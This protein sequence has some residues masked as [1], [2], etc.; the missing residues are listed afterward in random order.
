M[1]KYEPSS[2]SPYWGSTT[3]IVIGVAV[4][5]L[6][7]A[8]MVYFRPIIGPLLLSIIMTYLLYPVVENLAR[9]THLS[10]RITVNIVYIVLIIVLLAFFAAAGF[11]L[12]QQ[13][14]SLANV[15]TDFIDNLPNLVSS[16][17]GQ[18]I[19]IGPFRADLTHLNFNSLAK[20]ALA[21]LQP[22]LGQT[23]NLLGTVATGTIGFFGWLA[24][25]V[26]ISYF[27]LSEYRK[28]GQDGTAPYLEFPGYN[29]DF[30]RLSRELNRIWNAFLRGQIF[31]VLIACVVYLIVFSLLGVRFSLVLGI[32]AGMA[33]FVP[34]FGQWTSII[35][36]ALIT[37]FQASNYLGIPAPY[38]TLVVVICS[39]FIDLIMDNLVTPRIIG[40]SLGLHPAV[41]L[42]AA[43]V[44]SQLI[45]FTGLV[46]AAPMVG[47]L[48]LLGR[49]VSRK[50]F[51][52]DPWLEPDVDIP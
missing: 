42:V 47:T 40:Q 24:F 50:L 4:V 3:K 29:Y 41:I 43:L 5:A 23:G 17:P 7:G 37:Y 45:G 51:N 36:T 20:Q 14:Q 21:N 31:V 1:N 33:R 11:A 12:L 34:Y 13:A 28:T 32:I 35:V 18:E 2:K 22:M 52:L 16:I 44:G 27:I 26:L 49:Y 9:Y 30:Y 10:W 46:L 8:L 39:M 25:E 15:V 48:L 19:V 38:Y 6:I